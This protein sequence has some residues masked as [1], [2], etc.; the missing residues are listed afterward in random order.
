MIGGLIEHIKSVAQSRMRRAIQSLILM[1]VVTLCG[2]VSLGFATYSAF[3]Y[4]RSLEGEVFAALIIAAAYGAI[5]VVTLGISLAFRRADPPHAAP[6]PQP[7]PTTSPADAVEPLLT[8]LDPAA[9]PRDRLALLAATQVGRE[10]SPVQLVALAA[11]G[12]FL[13]GRKLGKHKKQSAS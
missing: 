8:S 2:L 11:V 9:D 10:L 12:G 1:A 6:A 7:V 5:S 13:A 4:L 3:L